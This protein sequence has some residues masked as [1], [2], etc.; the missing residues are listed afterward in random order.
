MRE[1]CVVAPHCVYGSGN[2]PS[3]DACC[4]AGFNASSSLLFEA[5]LGW[6]VRA[7]VALE[8]EVPLFLSCLYTPAQAVWRP[9]ADLLRLQN[10]HHTRL[11]REKAAL[12]MFSTVAYGTERRCCRA[13][14]SR[15]T[16]L[17]SSS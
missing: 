13:W 16:P 10:H 4:A 2:V 7:V 15:R 3:M 8:P 1:Q 9:N 6:K 5:F 14:P 11:L 17:P 12:N